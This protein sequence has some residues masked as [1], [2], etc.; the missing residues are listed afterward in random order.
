MSSRDLNR[1]AF[2][3]K[4]DRD[5]CVLLLG[6]TVVTVRVTGGRSLTPRHT[7]CYRQILQLLSSQSLWTAPHC[8]SV[9]SFAGKLLLLFHLCLDT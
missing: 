8:L 3:Q 4:A 9:L 7:P 2:F 6:S 1:G 5:G